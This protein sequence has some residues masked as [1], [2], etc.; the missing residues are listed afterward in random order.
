MEHAYVVRDTN[1]KRGSE[2]TREM[3]QGKNFG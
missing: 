3:Y 1:Q 2:G